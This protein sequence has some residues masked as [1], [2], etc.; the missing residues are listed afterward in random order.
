MF[1][2]QVTRSRHVTAFVERA[3]DSQLEVNSLDVLPQVRRLLRPL[4]AR[5]ADE[6]VGRMFLG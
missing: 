6:V 5:Q 2:Q 3:G 1:L 4:A